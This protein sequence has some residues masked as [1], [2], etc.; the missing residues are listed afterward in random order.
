MNVKI[1]KFDDLAM[2]IPVGATIL[3]EE[4]SIQSNIYE[5][6]GE[7]LH[8]E[9]REGEHVIDAIFRLYDRIKK[10]KETE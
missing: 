6:N 2:Q 7:V 5:C 3:W 8:E 1:I 9:W 10:S 4:N